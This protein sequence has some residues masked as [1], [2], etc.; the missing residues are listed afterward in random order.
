MPKKVYDVE[1]VKR[2]YGEGLSTYEIAKK[3]SGSAAGVASLLR[4][5]GVQLRSHAAAA[6]PRTVESLG[7]D[8]T[9][10]WLEQA[11][12]AFNGNAHACA[13][14]YGFNYP[15]F[16]AALRRRGV[17]A[18]GPKGR[19]TREEPEWVKEAVRLS[20]VGTSYSEIS[21]KL[22]ILYAKLVYWMR[23]VGHTVTRKTKPRRTLIPS[24]WKVFRELK[25]AEGDSC[26][27]CPEVRTLDLCHIHGAKNG[28][29]VVVTNCLLLCPTHHRLFDSGSLTLAE[30]EKIRSKVRSA[31][32]V[33]KLF[34]PHYRDW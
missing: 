22:G 4:R 2:M 6:R 18:K 15:T 24:K 3:L 8:P 19:F 11:M 7:F 12:A 16:Y 17:E 33:H 30:F 27:I 14:H 26:R 29:P 34:F 21:E 28:G 10:E 13:K 31:E 25:T 9:R 20:D 5:E 1:V 23:R 32:Q